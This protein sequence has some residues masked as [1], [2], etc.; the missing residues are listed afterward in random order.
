M[1]KPISGPIGPS[2]HFFCLFMYQYLYSLNSSRWRNV[3]AEQQA[4][5][6]RTIR[7]T[8]EEDVV[9]TSSRNDSDQRQ[10]TRRSFLIAE[11]KSTQIAGARI[12]LLL[13]PLETPAF[14]PSALQKILDDTAVKPGLRV[15][16]QGR[17]TA[18]ITSRSRKRRVTRIR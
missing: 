4:T 2:I 15:S 14:R 1:K 6:K 11:R 18:G 8:R 16:V 17:V 12:S 5:R 10:A 3:P 13:K 9:T 7:A